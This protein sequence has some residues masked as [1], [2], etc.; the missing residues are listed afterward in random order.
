MRPEIVASVKDLR[1]DGLQ[2]TL[3]K[4]T[5]HGRALSSLDKEKESTSKVPEKQRSLLCGTSWQK[6]YIKLHDDILKNR[7]PPRYLVYFCGGRRYGC[8]CLQ[9]VRTA[10]HTLGPVYMEVGDPR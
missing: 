1:Q 4:K 6:D 3:M 10:G 7:R 8:G 5:V 2:N 9:A